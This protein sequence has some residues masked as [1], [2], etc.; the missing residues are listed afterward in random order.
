MAYNDWLILNPTSGT[1][2]GTVNATISSHSGYSTRNKNVKISATING[3][4]KE[5]TITFNQI[6][7][8]VAGVGVIKIDGSILT[9]SAITPSKLKS[10]G[11]VEFH[12]DG[13]NARDF[14]FTVEAVEG[15][16]TPAQLTGVL[17]APTYTGTTKIT[18]VKT[19]QEV[20]LTTFTV[21]NA[22]KPGSVKTIYS[23]DN[24]TL[25][26]KLGEN[27]TYSIHVKTTPG[28]YNNTSSQQVKIK[29]GI[30]VLTGA[31]STTPVELKSFTVT[32]PP[33]TSFI[34]TGG[35]N[36]P[37]TSSSQPIRITAPSDVTWTAQIV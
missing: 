15:N 34:V 7:E 1:G 29:Y 30:S 33:T 36:I 22:S 14:Q 23:M 25:G 31:T 10:I 3:E 27:Q 28:S 35:G 18:D 37:I 21:S 12:I 11:S 9:D 8:S 5:E 19:G 17:S 4:T 32:Y 6:G 20:S 13:T 24:T 2:N 16:V 26:K